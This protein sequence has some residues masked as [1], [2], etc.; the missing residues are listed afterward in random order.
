[1]GVVF[2][3][4]QEV[5]DRVVALKMVLSGGLNEDEVRR[6][7]AEGEAAAR[8]DHPGIVSVFEVGEH[9]GH[10]FFS[11]AY[12]DGKSLAHRL[13][14]GPLPAR[15][16]AELVTAVAGAVAHAHARGV[17]H[18]GLKP[19]SIL[20]GADG[21]PRGSDFGLAKRVG[22]DSGLTVTG[23]ILGTP[24]Y[25]PPEQAK[26]QKEVGPAADI[27]ALGAVLY[28]LLVG[29]PPFQGPSAIETVRQVLE[30]EPVPPRRLNASLPRDLETICLKCL[31]K[32]PE[33]RYRSARELADDLDRY[34][35]HRPILARPVSRRERLL[36]W[37]RRSPF[38]AA[39]LVAAGA[40]VLAL[41]AALFAGLQSAR[42]GEEL[43]R[44]ELAASLQRDTARGRFTRLYAAAEEAA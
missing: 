10:P 17:I 9:E 3:A 23:Q 1:M 40:F 20:V 43:Q 39:A 34:L 15:E 21:R 14:G 19:S 27:Y 32:R 7:R 38:Q 33:E 35:S 11:M 28:T 6:L 8:L 24:S 42:R 22:G 44:K 5:P 26:G 30:Q 41:F 4:R 2:K 31:R 37:V 12:V 29:R 13:Q 36:K 25:M 18:R 16:A